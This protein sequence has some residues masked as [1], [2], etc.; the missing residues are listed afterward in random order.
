MSLYKYLD[1]L[2][3]ECG[4]SSAS[5]MEMLQSCTGISIYLRMSVKIAI[6]I[7]NINFQGSFKTD[8][9]AV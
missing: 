1:D 3:R 4:I 5:A 8:L 9:Q 7:M 2:L 6:T